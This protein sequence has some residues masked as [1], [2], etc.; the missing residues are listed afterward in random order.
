L[1]RFP[2]NYL[3]GA[4]VSLPV[5]SIRTKESFGVGE[6][7]DLKKVVD[8]ASKTGLKMIQVLPVNDTQSTNSFLDSYP[9]KA[10]SVFALHPLFLNI[11]KAGKIKD[12][13]LFDDY[14]NS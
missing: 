4:G 8:W 13:V 11:F 10:I 5:F 12:S 2:D 7:T 14:D 6:F 1:F 9:Y 3:R